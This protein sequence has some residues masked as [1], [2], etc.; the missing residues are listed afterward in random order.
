MVNDLPDF[1]FDGLVAAAGAA[2]E[3]AQGDE[4]TAAEIEAR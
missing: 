3:I 2:F 1:S 4:T